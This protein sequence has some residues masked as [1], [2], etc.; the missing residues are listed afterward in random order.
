[1]EK[2]TKFVNIG[3][4]SKM[5]PDELEK[6]AERSNKIKIVFTK[7]LSPEFKMSDDTLIEKLF[8]ILR[9]QFIERSKLGIS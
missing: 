8:S 5:P 2:E 1:M 3:L 6:E 9:S 4:G 7:L